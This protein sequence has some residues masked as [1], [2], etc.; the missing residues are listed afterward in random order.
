MSFQ[1]LEIWLLSIRTPKYFGKNCLSARNHL[2]DLQDK[3]WGHANKVP[4]KR[5][6]IAEDQRE[7]SR[8]PN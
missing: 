5:L 6:E 1:I 4:G 7:Q 8:L 2:P 3:N